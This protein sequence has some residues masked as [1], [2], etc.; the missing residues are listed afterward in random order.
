MIISYFFCT[1]FPLDL[2]R[3]RFTVSYCRFTVYFTVQAGFLYLK[4]L[5]KMIMQHVGPI[6]SGMVGGIKAF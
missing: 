2:G 5:L 4:Q 1:G 3:F 6:N